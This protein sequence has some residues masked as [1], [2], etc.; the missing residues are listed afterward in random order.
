[1]KTSKWIFLLV[2][3]IFITFLVFLSLKENNKDGN[4]NAN[5]TN[6][7]QANRAE[8]FKKCYVTFDPKG[9]KRNHRFTVYTQ[10]R[11]Q[12]N[13]YWGFTIA[14]ERNLSNHIYSDQYRII[15]SKEFI[16]NGKKMSSTGAKLLYLG[17]SEFAYKRSGASDFT[18]G[19]HGREKFTDVS[20]FI[21]DVL[22]NDIT[23]GFKMRACE[24]FAYRQN[25][26]MYRNDDIRTKDAVHNKITEILDSG[27]FTKNTI[28]AI[29]NLPL[30]VCF[31]SI[32]SV[33]IDV[34]GKGQV[35]N[36]ENAIDFN[37]DGNRKLEGFCD[38]LFMW[39]DQNKLSVHIESMFE[40]YNDYATQ[41]I[42]DDKYY[43]KYYRHLQYIN[44]DAGKSWSFE[45]KVT[46]DK[47]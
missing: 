19:Y 15:Q 16:Y 24:R 31:G 45:T 29:E 2:I 11:T 34:A 14:R 36:Y 4:T 44:L 22:I 28:T 20:F 37:R 3:S 9:H 30:E 40:L 23:T 39:N 13:Y 33:S 25:S 32:V 35:A 21:D 6:S 7:F 17:E 41:Q 42:W 43:G 26:I 18:G 1:M 46:F 5:E 10:S 27:Y 12:P 47:L 38:K 8:E